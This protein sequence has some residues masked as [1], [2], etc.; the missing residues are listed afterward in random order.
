[1]TD[2]T[3]ALSASVE[4]AR[5]GRQLLGAAILSVHTKDRR[6]NEVTLVLISRCRGAARG[7]VCHAKQAAAVRIRLSPG[8]VR[9]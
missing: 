9:S 6:I 8:V 5:Q 3:S 4:A 2:L 1:M 7:G